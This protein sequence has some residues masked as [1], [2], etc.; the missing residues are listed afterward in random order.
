[1]D[2]EAKK[3][4]F[5]IIYTATLTI[6]LTYLWWGPYQNNF[7]AQISLQQEYWNQTNDLKTKGFDPIAIAQ[8][9]KVQEVSIEN[10]SE[11][12]RA[13][14]IAFMVDEGKENQNTNK[15]NY[16]KYYIMD[17]M[18]NCSDARNLSLNGNIYTSTLES[19]EKEEYKIVLWSDEEEMNLD[20]NLSLI[21]NPTL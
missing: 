19:G 16:V 14:T 11:G 3:L 4:I 1:M 8:E 13:Y 2:K 10:T 12:E 6:L 5:K 17:E 9:A 15:N 18:G 21:A 7:R 20:G